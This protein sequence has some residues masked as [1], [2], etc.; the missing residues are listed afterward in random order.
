[1]TPCNIESYGVNT[2]HLV[3]TR[4]Q[5]TLVKFQPKTRRMGVG[6]L[7]LTGLRP[8]VQLSLIHI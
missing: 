1:M 6:E 8:A 5:D 7:F 3:A 2:N 4:V